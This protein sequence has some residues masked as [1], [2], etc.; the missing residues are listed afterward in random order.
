MVLENA[1]KIVSTYRAL[2]GLNKGILRLQV[3]QTLKALIQ[4]SSH[5]PSGETRERESKIILIRTLR[6]FFNKFKCLLYVMCALPGET[7]SNN[8]QNKQEI[9]IKDG[10]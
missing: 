7:K 4:S 10:E 6:R 3:K 5:I 1:V 9:K 2:E 8:K